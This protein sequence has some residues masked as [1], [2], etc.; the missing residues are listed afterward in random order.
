MLKIPY[1]YLKYSIESSCKQKIK[2]LNVEELK[3]EG[4]IGKVFCVLFIWRLI[5]TLLIVSR[6][7]KEPLNLSRKISSS[8]RFGP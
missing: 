3:T 7:R 4:C 8:H 1:S 6:S 5:L 2:K